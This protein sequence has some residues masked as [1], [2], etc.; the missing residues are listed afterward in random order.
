[1]LARRADTLLAIS[2]AM[3]VAAALGVQLGRSA[4]AEIDPIHFLGAAAAPRGID[5]DARRPA[6]DAFASAY[7]WDQGYAARA[8]DCGGDCD[9][10]Q[11][12]LALIHAVEP[13]AAATAEPAPWQPGETAARPLSVEPYMHYPIEGD[14]TATPP[15][16][17]VGDKTLA[18]QAPMQ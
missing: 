16:E 7:G 9:A 12:R 18:E 13:P 8:A 5:P 15:E 6:P 10:R 1:M 3:L 4:V 2:V 11:A 14:S 17:S